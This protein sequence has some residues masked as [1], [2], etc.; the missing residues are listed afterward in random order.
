MHDQ[1]M[2]NTTGGQNFN[3][4]LGEK[5]LSYLQ[6][7][8]HMKTDLAGLSLDGHLRNVFFLC[9]SE[10]NRPFYNNCGPTFIWD[11]CEWKNYDIARKIITS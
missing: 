7:L 1:Y 11:I 3:I 6:P 2:T 8:N 5:C 10:I 9:R 4:G